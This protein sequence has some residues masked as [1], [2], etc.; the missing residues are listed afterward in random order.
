MV[1][2]R[3]RRSGDP[4][5]TSH[6]L[7]G[8]L[9]ADPQRRRSH[10]HPRLQQRPRRQ[11][12]FRLPPKIRRPRRA[13]RPREVKRPIGAARHTPLKMCYHETEAGQGPGEHPGENFK[14]KGRE[15][16]EGGEEGEGVSWKGCVRMRA[17]GHVDATA[18]PR[19]GFRIESNGIFKFYSLLNAR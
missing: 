1:L 4:S 9:N 2:P 12:H 7:P 10:H 14:G 13:C 6:P 17:M 8:S 15:E 18:R 5:L 11:S 19:F 16:V 3:S